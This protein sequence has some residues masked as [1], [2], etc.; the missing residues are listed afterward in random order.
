[1][2]FNRQL[3]LFLVLPASFINAKPEL[4]ADVN[5]PFVF[6][7]YLVMRQCL[8]VLAISWKELNA[9]LAAEYCSTAAAEDAE[10][11][12][13]FSQSFTLV[14]ATAKSNKASLTPSVS[15]ATSAASRR[16]RSR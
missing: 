3:L 16:A 15:C 7:T 4:G 1:M 11:G 13:F 5:T 6:G 2:I 9:A 10:D 8:P 12:W 14:I